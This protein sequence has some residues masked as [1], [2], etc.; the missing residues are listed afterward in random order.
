MSHHLSIVGKTTQP[1]IL[2]K[3]AV[4]EY[5][6]AT[7]RQRTAESQRH[8]TWQLY[9]F[10]DWCDQVACISLEKIDARAVD[11]FLDY[12]ETTARPHKQGA[13]AISKVTI[14]G[15]VQI[16]KTFINWAAH[17]HAVY[18]DF[19][20]ESTVKGI[21]RPKIPHIIQVVLTGAQ[22]RALLVA[23]EKEESPRMVARARALL[24]TL[25]GTGIRAQECCNLKLQDVS[26]DAIKVVQG[27]GA[28]DRIIPLG[29]ITR[30]K[31]WHY[32]DTWRAGQPPTAPVFTTRNGVE[33]MTPAG[34]QQLMERLAQRAGIEGR[35]SPH[36][37]RHYFACESVKRGMDILTLSKLL[38]HQNVIMTQK[39]LAGLPASDIAARAIPYL[40]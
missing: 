40:R 13:T 33:K 17:D 6:A 3:P 26:E 16:I 7:H 8:Y 27:K 10:A 22:I 20:E 1:G 14:A 21:H 28:R 34:L 36:L 5:L 15:L 23:C 4:Q 19:V 2:V 9:A 39:Y 24:F 18:G 25:T 38:G 12:Y 37:C 29:S 31:L 30:H 35:C 32:I 11:A